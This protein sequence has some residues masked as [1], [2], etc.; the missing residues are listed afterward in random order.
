MS[1][2]GFNVPIPFDRARYAR[3]RLI[4]TKLRLVLAERARTAN[5]EAKSAD[6]AGPGSDR[7]ADGYATDRDESKSDQQNW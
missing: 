4:E 1:F 2:V 6:P 5:A 7:G 3:E